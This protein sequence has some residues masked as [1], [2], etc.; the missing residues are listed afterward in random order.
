LRPV[1]LEGL[2]GDRRLGGGGRLGHGRVS[3]CCG[4]GF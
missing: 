4:D 1:G 3:I 2:L